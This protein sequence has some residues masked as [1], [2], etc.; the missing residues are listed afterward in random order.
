MDRRGKG[1]GKLE[2]KVED[3]S[4]SKIGKNAENKRNTWPSV[5]EEGIGCGDEEK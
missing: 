2:G 1:S 3:R 5:L 4:W